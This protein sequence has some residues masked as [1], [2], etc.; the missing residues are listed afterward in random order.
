MKTEDL[1]TKLHDQYKTYPAPIQDTEAFCHDISKIS[2]EGQSTAE[3]DLLASHRRQQRLCE[4]NKSHESASIEIIG[5]PNV[6]KMP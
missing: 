3:F 1:F 6:I 5:N 2:Y 4:L